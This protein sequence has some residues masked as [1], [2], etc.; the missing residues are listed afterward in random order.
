MLVSRSIYIDTDVLLLHN[1]DHLAGLGRHEPAFVLRPDWELLN[2]GV[3]SLHASR[4]SFDTFWR[5]VG[6]HL[7]QKR[8]PGLPCGGADGSD[9]AIW[10]YYLIKMPPRDGFIELPAGYNAYAWQMNNT[11]AAMPW[12]HQVHVLHKT[13]RLT[14]KGL[15]PECLGYFKERI[16]VLRAEST[17]APAWLASQQR[18]LANMVARST[19]T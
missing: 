7:K 19:A 18:L 12:C 1:L 4:R 5:I 8:Q 11:R 15:T 3:F 2:S 6:H 16:R 17:A 9:Q 10:I 13:T 14:R